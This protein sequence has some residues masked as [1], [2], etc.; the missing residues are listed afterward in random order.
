MMSRPLAAK[1]DSLLSHL[2]AACAE[3]YGD[4]LISLAVYGSVGRGTP[5]PDSDIDILVV[6][7][8]LPRG[9][10]ARMAGFEAV[11]VAMKPWLAAVTILYHTK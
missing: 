2:A 6:A 4:R 3:C 8:D 9:R 7:D 1:F 11:E 10:M 5:R